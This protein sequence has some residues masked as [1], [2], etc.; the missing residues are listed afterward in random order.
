MEIIKI[1]LGIVLFFF[2]TWVQ[3]FYLIVGTIVYFYFK[4]NPFLQNNSY[5]Y[6]FIYSMI[7]SIDFV[8]NVLN[9]LWKLIKKNTYINYLPLKLEELNNK[10]LQYKMKFGFYLLGK[11]TKLFFSFYRKETSKNKVEEN[12]KT[13]SKI[14]LDTNDEIASFLEKIEY[15][16]KK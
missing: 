1:L 3:I 11:L 8:F 12:K 15:N 5:E 13:I 9:Y 6:N 10:Y 2:I 16:L 7:Y 4:Y 14:K